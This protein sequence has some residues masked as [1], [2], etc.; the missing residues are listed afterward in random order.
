MSESTDPTVQ[1]PEAPPTGLTPLAE[2]AVIVTFKK[3]VPL[4]VEID[5]DAIRWQQMKIIQR[6]AQNSSEEESTEALL[7]LLTTLTGQDA[8]QFSMRQINSLIEQIGKLSEAVN[9]KN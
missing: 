6:F 1:S 9:P 3:M 4:Q 5:V 7:D 2:P 8:R